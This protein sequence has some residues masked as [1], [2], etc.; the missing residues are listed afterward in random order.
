[1]E[2]KVVY[3]YGLVD[4]RDRKLRYIGKAHDPHRRYIQ[5]L[6]V[7]RHAKRRTYRD[8][9]ILKLLTLGL[10]PGLE[11]LEECDEGTW[12]ESERFWIKEAMQA[13]LKLTNTSQGGKGGP[14]GD[15]HPFYGGG[16]KVTPE[17][18]KKMSI[19]ARQRPPIKEETRIKM[20]Q[21]PQAHMGPNRGLKLP[22]EWK[23]NIGNAFKGKPKTE[24]H[25][26]KNSLTVGM[27]WSKRRGNLQEIYKLQNQYF[28]LF[29]EYNEKYPI[30]GTGESHVSDGAE[31]SNRYGLTPEDLRAG[32]DSEFHFDFTPC[33]YPLSEGFDGLEVEWGK[34]NYVS[35]S[36]KGP[37]RWVYKAIEEYEKG[38]KVIFVF[39]V[40]K[41][42]YQMIEA[43][44]EIRNLKDVNWLDANN[45]QPGNGNRRWLAAFI[46]D[47]NKRKC[48]D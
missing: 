21:R 6:S 39:P 47:P 11:I 15:K 43:G 30:P 24:D 34:V 36:F 12:E 41:W 44:A 27:M 29:G 40:D 48:E 26:K 10:K 4:P 14:S 9:W 22:E 28:E 35:P 16:D 32:L 42:I 13:G 18:R 38:K 23:R 5:H 25:N 7:A 20:G 37:T 17:T 45:D 3:I 1:M 31:D 19:S 2:S 46:L 33:S 8:N